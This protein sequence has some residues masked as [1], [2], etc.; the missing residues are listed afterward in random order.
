MAA[1]EIAGTGAKDEHK[2]KQKDR[3]GDNEKGIEGPC[4]AKPSRRF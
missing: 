4:A 1:T 2:R 3:H